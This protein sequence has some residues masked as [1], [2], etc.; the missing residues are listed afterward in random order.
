LAHCDAG[1]GSRPPHQDRTIRAVEIRGTGPPAFRIRQLRELTYPDAVDPEPPHRHNFHE[2]IWVCDGSGRHAID[3]R[4]QEI[5]A[6]TFYL[7]AQGRVHQ[8][9]ESE[10][11]DG[12]VVN[13]TD[14]QLPPADG[15]EALGGALFNNVTAI[16]EVRVGDGERTGYT[17]LFRLMTAEAEAAD[18]YGRAAA[19]GHLLRVLMIRLERALRARR[20]RRRA[21]A[22]RPAARLPRTAGNRPP[23]P[24]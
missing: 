18:G 1:G 5:R 11:L 21:A 17:D 15:G 10:D 16:R 7:I 6:G 20:H 24:P 3:G 2:L 8:F 14:D 22:R 4:V 23:P 19:L 13:F 12:F 9:L